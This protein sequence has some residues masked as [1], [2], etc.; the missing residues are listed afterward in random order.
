MHV[1]IHTVRTLNGLKARAEVLAAEHSLGHMK[2][3]DQ[4]AKE[5][6]FSSYKKAQQAMP[7]RMIMIEVKARWHETRYKLRGT[8]SMSYPF[9]LP[10]E[11]MLSPV[12]G[13]RRQRLG[14]FVKTADNVLE[15]DMTVDKQG[16]ARRRV[17]QAIRRLMFMEALGVNL[18]PADVIGWPTGPGSNRT[19]NELRMPGT[20]H[21]SVWVTQEGAVV[22]VDEPYLDSTGQRPKIE[23]QLAW[24]DE[25]GFEMAVPVWK[26]MWNPEGGTHM[27]LLAHKDSG[28]DLQQMAD[29]LVNLPDDFGQKAWPGISKSR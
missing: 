28:L 21:H 18:A 15:F 11:Q 13:R 29:K 4:A 27:A 16:E 25:N 19:D 1:S 26:G 5:L 23:Q 12:K 6:G 17:C 7:A 22:I 3:L 9:M 20:D 8:E 24:C 10:L 14:M 2:S